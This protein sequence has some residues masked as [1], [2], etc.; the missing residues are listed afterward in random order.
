MTRNRVHPG[1]V[2]RDE[3]LAP[4]STSV[5]QLATHLGVPPLVLA[6]IVAERAPIDKVMA[7]RLATHYR[8]SAQFWLN[9]Q[10][11]FDRTKIK[12]AE[13]MM[14]EWDFT[15]PLSPEAQAEED[16]WVNMKPV[17][18]EWGS[19]EWLAE[20]EPDTEEGRQ[21]RTLLKKNPT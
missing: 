8:Q 2:L 18:K 1:E 12:S 13:K 16:A 3:F 21:A 14:V 4:S 17:G 19:P 9:L 20:N 5:E 15:R 7:E 10:S 11:A 6:E